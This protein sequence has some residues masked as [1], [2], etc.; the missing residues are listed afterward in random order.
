MKRVLLSPFTHADDIHLC[1]NMISFLFKGVS[2]E[3][4][5]HMQDYV[6]LLLFSTVASQV[7]LLLA[8]CVLMALGADGAMQSCTVGFSG[9]LFALKYIVSRWSPGVTNVSKK[10]GEREG[11]VDT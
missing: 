6:G 4:T 5:M 1:Y 7:L 3:L 9:V 2:L 11:G 10:S 8:S